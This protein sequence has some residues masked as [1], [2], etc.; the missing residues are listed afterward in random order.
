MGGDEGQLWSCPVH[1]CCALNVQA[2]LC[3]CCFSSTTKQLTNQAT[4]FFGDPAFADG[5]G[6]GVG[7][8]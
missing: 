2:G 3:V 8:C 6:P 4:L 7:G 1:V 5:A